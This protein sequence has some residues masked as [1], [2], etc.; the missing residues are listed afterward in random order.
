M[1]PYK[2]NLEELVKGK[3]TFYI[4]FR[5]IIWFLTIYISVYGIAFG[6]L[7]LSTK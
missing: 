4:Y 1:N 6:A 3:K 7:Y 2:I 5:I